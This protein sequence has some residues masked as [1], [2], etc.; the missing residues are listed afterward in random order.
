MDRSSDLRSSDAPPEY[1]PLTKYLDT[2]FADAVCLTFSQ[3]ADVIGMPLPKSAYDDRAWWD[4]PAET[5]DSTPQAR[6]WIRASRVA[7]VN[8]SARTVIFDRTPA[9][10]RA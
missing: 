1:R 8:L 3:I 7:T 4:G 6:A 10:R 9:G 5:G 2:R